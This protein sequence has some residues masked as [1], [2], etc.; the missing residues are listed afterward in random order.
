M[1]ALWVLMSLVCAA[2][3][4]IW[5]QQIT[6]SSSLARWMAVDHEQNCFVSGTIYG[7]GDAANFG[8]TNLPAGS[9]FAR[10]SRSGN[11]VYAHPTDEIRSLVM[12]GSKLMAVE[13]TNLFEIRDDGRKSLRARF[14]TPELY[15]TE[16]SAC[17]ENSFMVSGYFR[18]SLTVDGE[19]L[20]GAD[21]D[22]WTPFIARLNAN[23]NVIWKTVLTTPG[24]AAGTRSGG[25]YL[26]TAV[27][28]PEPLWGSMYRPVF[29]VQAFGRRGE[30]LW[31]REVP[32][33]YLGVT[34]GIAADREGNCF[35]TGTFRGEMEVAGTVL[36]SAQSAYV[37]GLARDGA[38]H[39]AG[40]P[41]NL[42]MVSKS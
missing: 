28:V 29:T 42:T 37:I 25:A 13:G 4:Q 20:V 31:N 26:L 12:V 19:M 14:N 16:M 36:G 7:D 24:V 23:G 8:S 15:V 11:L 3:G 41:T 30:L 1:K 18:S 6:G 35:I 27:Q 17:N 21:V 2:S 5:V 22:A 9:F 32:G 10:Y 38:F 40:I 39:L 33:T 34:A